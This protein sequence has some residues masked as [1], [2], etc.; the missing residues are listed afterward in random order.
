MP[1]F[2]RKR[3]TKEQVSVDEIM[4][5]GYRPGR[6]VQILRPDGSKLK[7]YFATVESVHSPLS[8]PVVKVNPLGQP[9]GTL[10]EFNPPRSQR[11]PLKR[12]VVVARV[13]ITS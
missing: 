8:G 2:S 1:G 5:M 10:D 7:P 4:S 12:V 6:L 9:L 13:E 3:K 11:H